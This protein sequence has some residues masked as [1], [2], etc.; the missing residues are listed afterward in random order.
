[1]SSIPWRKMRGQSNLRQRLRSASLA[2]GFTLVELLVVIGIIAILI[3][4]L[5]PALQKAR[6][7]ALG[8]ACESN[9]RQ[10]GQAFVMYADDNDGYAPVVWSTDS[11]SPVHY[12]FWT[13]YLEKYVGFTT[14]FS[15]LGRITPNGSGYTLHA[16]LGSAMGV[17]HCPAESVMLYDSTKLPQS[18]YGNSDYALNYHFGTYAN[19]CHLL[20]MPHA[21]RT[22][23]VCDAQWSYGTGNAAI[24]DPLHCGQ[25]IDDNDIV[26]PANVSPLKNQGQAKFRHTG[27]GNDM[28]VNMLWCDGHVTPV[29]RRSLVNSITGDMGNPGY[30]HV[31]SLPP[32]AP[33]SG[34]W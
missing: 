19:N 15:S 4:L 29:A 5:L 22:Y 24:A 14:P 17:F 12:S 27:T 32:W 9:L 6:A 18:D 13:T 8:V 23:L 7:Q 3:A 26:S 34:R 25:S 28:V 20:G 10:I 30:P 2:H 31:A 11:T 1:M 16:Y 21:A 33:S